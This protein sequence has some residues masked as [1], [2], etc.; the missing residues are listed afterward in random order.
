[1]T[2]DFSLPRPG[3]VQ[4]GIFDASGRLV[5]TA[6]DQTMPAG[7]HSLRWN[8]LDLHAAPV[9]AG[10]YYFELRGDGQRLGRP[11]VLIR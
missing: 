9:P 6:P 7:R 11:L 1:M 8:R 3:A 10:V 4:A 2:I 5:W